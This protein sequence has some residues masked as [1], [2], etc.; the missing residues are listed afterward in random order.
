MLLGAHGVKRGPGVSPP[1]DGDERGKGD[2]AQ[3]DPHLPETLERGDDDEEQ[4]HPADDLEDD[5]H[6]AGTLTGSLGLYSSK[7]R[8]GTSDAKSS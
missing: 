2:Q 1:R 6:E 3:E 8:L 4:E 7:R 5:A